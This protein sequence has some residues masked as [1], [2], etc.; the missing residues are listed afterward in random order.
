META[1]P[2]QTNRSTP[3]PAPEPQM[4]R[5]RVV[6]VFQELQNKRA[7]LP[8]DLGKARDDV[9]NILEEALKKERATSAD[10]QPAKNGEALEEAKARFA[11]AEKN[12]AKGA[13]WVTVL[14]DLKEAILPIL[15]RLEKR[16]AALETTVDVLV[17]WKVDTE[18]MLDLRQCSILLQPEVSEK[19]LKK[20][21]K[22]RELKDA[23]RGQLALA[24]PGVYGIVN[25]FGVS[26]GNL[27]HRRPKVSAAK[28]KAFILK[29][30][31]DKFTEQDIDAF[32]TFLNRALQ[33][34]DAKLDL[35]S[36]EVTLGTEDTR[37]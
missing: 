32:L 17:Q 2:A 26:G 25:T 33:K 7:V 36:Q 3:G 23:E 21:V 20:R 19:I 18:A 28:L 14:A 29:E 27:V 4:Y 24:L 9:L 31:S 6:D 37:E 12:L 13:P 1:T 11:E 34:K 8:N 10:R 22:F 5:T 35:F 30:Y 16:T 15:E